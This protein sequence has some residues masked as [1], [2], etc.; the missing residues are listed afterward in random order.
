VEDDGGLEC[1]AV[2]KLG[3]GRKRATEAGSGG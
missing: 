1:G 2:R 3:A